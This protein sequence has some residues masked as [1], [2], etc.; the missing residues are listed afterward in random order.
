MTQTPSKNKAALVVVTR[1]NHVL[2]QHFIDS[3]ERHDA[4]FPWDL[5]IADNSSD[6]V[7]HKKF[8]DSIAKK[9]EITH[10]ANDRVEATFNKACA[11][12]RGQYAYHMFFHDD[13]HINENG[14]LKKHVDRMLS[15]YA[16]PQASEFASLPIGRVGNNHQP[17]R[18]YTSIAGYPIGSLFL[19]EALRIL[20]SSAPNSYKF[21]D[22]ERVL[23]SD[24]C[25]TKCGIFS[26]F[27]FW[28]LKHEPVFQE[29][30]EMLK[31]YLPYE[32][33]GIAPKN[34]Y[35]PGQ[36]WNKMTMV[37]EFMN[38]VRPLMCGYRSVGLE[39]DGYLEQIDGFNEPW[40]HKTITHYG[41]PNLKRFLASKFNTTGEEIHKRLYSRDRTFL[42]QCDRIIQG[43][44][45]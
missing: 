15:N 14:W 16:E 40:G 38:S 2:L 26:V 21:V 9:Y 29:M 45:K 22:P 5:Y 25:L 10:Y 7:A 1:N 39:G 13:T 30:C 36:A 33:E 19:K 11:F 18:D 35:P 43:H 28:E 42:L 27:S 31:H 32:D 44:F 41:S 3:L 24:E 20:F 4:G 34:L 6:D 37:S 23:Y 8:L 17:W 12:N